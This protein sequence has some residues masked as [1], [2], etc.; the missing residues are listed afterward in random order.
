M[1]KGPQIS[2]TGSADAPPESIRAARRVGRALGQNDAVLVCG[3]GGGV[4]EAAC[5]GIQET[6]GTSIGV[7]KGRDLSAGN[8]HLDLRLPSGVGHAR[9]LTVA[10]SGQA[11]IA[12]DGRLGT[13]T[14]L[15][16][17]LKFDRPVF[18]VGSWDHPSLPFDHDLSPDEAVRRAL[19]AAR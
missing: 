7:L 8:P 2:V 17:A 19:A 11:M 13:L 10:L 1:V 5:R 6:G 3:G 15:A 12:V 4:M 14:E 9:N 18:G 16:F